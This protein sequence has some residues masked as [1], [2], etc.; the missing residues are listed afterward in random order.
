MNH[1]DHLYI[2]QSSAWPQWRYDLAALA[3]PLAEVE[4]DPFNEVH[5]PS[6]AHHG[7]TTRAPRISGAHPQSGRRPRNR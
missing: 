4:D 3:R 1:G 6:A 5:S 7:R 2:W